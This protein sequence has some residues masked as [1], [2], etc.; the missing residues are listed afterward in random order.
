MHTCTCSIK[1]H[2]CLK[3]LRVSFGHMRH[4]R[5]PQLVYVPEHFPS[6]GCEHLAGSCRFFTSPGRVSAVLSPTA[7]PVINTPT[8]H[9]TP[10][11]CPSGVKSRKPT[12]KED[13]FGRHSC[14]KR[15]YNH[16][17]QGTVEPSMLSCIPIRVQM[18]STSTLAVCTRDC[19]VSLVFI[20]K[21]DIIC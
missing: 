18:S 7:P 20:S 16:R 13:S 2:V 12:L 4:A 19:N 15:H 10:Q 5:L 8:C 1:L 14:T 9:R 17:L 6:P 3:F 21:H 11:A